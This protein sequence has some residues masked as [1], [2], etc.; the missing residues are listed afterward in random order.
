MKAEAHGHRAVGPGNE[1]SLYRQAG[2]V[3]RDCQLHA[4]RKWKDRQELLSLPVELG[5]DASPVGNSGLPRKPRPRD[6]VHRESALVEVEERRRRV[7]DDFRAGGAIRSPAQ[8][9]RPRVEHRNA[10][11]AP[12]CRGALEI[13][14]TPQDLYP[15]VAERG[16]EHAVRRKD[17]RLEV[18]RDERVRARVGE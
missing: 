10:R 13:V 8:A 6:S 4:M 2:G 7:E 18:A 5:H 1:S 3:E 9:V 11:G 16:A 15:A 17:N 14:H 12:P